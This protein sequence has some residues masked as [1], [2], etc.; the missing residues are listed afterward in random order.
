VRPVRR[1]PRRARLAAAY[2]RCSERRRLVLALLLVERLTAAEAADAL[3]LSRPQVER[4]Y[5]EALDAVRRSARDRTAASRARR[6][7]AVERLR[8]AS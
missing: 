7:P 4:E 8:K 5:R 3:G 6:A 2:Q 1:D